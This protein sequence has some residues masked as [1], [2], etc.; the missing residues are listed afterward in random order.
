M[1]AEWIMTPRDVK[2]FGPDNDAAILH[3]SVTRELDSRPE[4]TYYARGAIMETALRL[5]TLV[6]HYLSEE[7]EVIFAPRPVV[8]KS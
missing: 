6:D 3:S 7:I 2:T 1:M 5:Q 8:T 4:I